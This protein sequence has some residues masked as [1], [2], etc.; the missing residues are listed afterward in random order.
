MALFLERSGLSL[1]QLEAM[2]GATAAMISY[3][4]RGRSSPSLARLQKILSAVGSD[5]GSFFAEGRPESARPVARR[6]KEPVR[7]VS[8]C[9][10]PQY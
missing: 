10:P 5:I 9:H 7:L 8:V 1:R 2:S 3:I 6:G 4:E